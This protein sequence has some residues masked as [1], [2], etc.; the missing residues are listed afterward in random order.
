MLIDGVRIRWGVSR[1][2]REIVCTFSV[3]EAC[4]RYSFPFATHEGVGSRVIE[5][6]DVLVNSGVLDTSARNVCIATARTEFETWGYRWDGA[7]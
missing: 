2:P 1:A 3:G 6:I 4:A 5:L 7:S